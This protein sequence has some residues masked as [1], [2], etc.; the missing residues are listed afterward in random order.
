M[1]PI[2]HR[3]LLTRASKKEA[4]L[5]RYWRIN[6]S[7]S[8]N[9]DQAP[10]C[11][12]R[13]SVDGD[14]ANILPEGFRLEAIP[15][16]ARRQ[17]VAEAS[18]CIYCGALSMRPGTTLACGEEHIVPEALGGQFIIK[19]AS[20]HACAVLI[21]SY[22]GDLLS[23]LFWLPR[24]KIGLKGKKRARERRSFLV[25]ALIDGQTTVVDLPI[26]DNPSFLTMPYFPIP[27]VLELDG[28]LTLGNFGIWVHQFEDLRRL[29]DHGV[30]EFTTPTI[31]TLKFTQLL[32]KI[33]HGYATWKMGLTWL[34]CGGGP[35]MGDY[36]AVLLPFIR[37]KFGPTEVFPSHLD[38]IGSFPGNYPPSS[39]LHEMGADFLLHKGEV[40]LMVLIRLFASLGAPVYW[41]IVGTRRS[42]EPE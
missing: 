1:P 7:V 3:S 15:P 16:G 14:L 18:E 31:D 35:M 28:K 22:E 39:S 13:P 4:S 32:A 24:N 34:S 26:E 23:R 5:S 19:R 20:C 40:Y 30:K 37:K 36:R 27:S 17:V 38:Y 29:W 9:S 8:P 2:S 11:G 10:I 33:A 12:E 42:D 25:H 6:L 21:N 41:V